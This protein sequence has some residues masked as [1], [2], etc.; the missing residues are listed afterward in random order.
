MAAV[1]HVDLSHVVTA[2]MV[3]YPGL[4]TPIIADHL[5]RDAAEV[6]YGLG[7]TFQIGR[8]TM[9]TNTGT[10]LDV[11]FHR[12]A[13]G[14]DLTALPI[15]RVAAVEAVRLDCRGQQA[16]GLDN[17]DVAA[18]AGKAVLIWT[19]HSRHWGTE[20]YF[21]DHPA[22]TAGA[23]ERLRNNDVACVGIDSLNIDATEGT[24]ER[25]VHTTLLRADIP[26]IEH[27]TNLAAIPSAGFTFT[28][29]PPKIEGA[30]TF[31]VRAYAT[32]PR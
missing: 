12:Y 30:G 22:L 17:V 7:I 31:T 18:L 2:G 9:C 6:I 19:D 29:V 4:P 32:V 5:S 27:L 24:G 25:P 3:T 15:D 21:A 16:I 13:D 26:I 28:A 20:A 14:H 10:Y 23:A 11:P 1:T 8:V